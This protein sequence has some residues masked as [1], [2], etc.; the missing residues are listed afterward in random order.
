[1]KSTQNLFLIRI[2]NIPG[3]WRAMSG[4]GATA[5]YTRDYSGGSTTPDLLPGPATHEDIEVVRTYDPVVD[6][7]WIRRLKK[8]VGRHRTTITKQPLDADMVAVGKPEVYDGVLLIGI[9]PPETD[10]SSADPADLTLTF[11]TVGSA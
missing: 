9:T 8:R 3:T 6:E 10:A 5:E 11:A 4:G 2:D 7:P 1:M